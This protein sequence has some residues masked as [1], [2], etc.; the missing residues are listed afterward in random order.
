MYFKPPSDRQLR[1]AAEQR[2]VFPEIQ[3]DSPWGATGF[4]LKRPANVIG[5]SVTAYGVGSGS[6]GTRADLLICDDVVDVRA[7]TAQFGR[8]R[9]GGRVFREQPDEPAEWQNWLS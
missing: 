4:T 1:L 7:F 5:A 2:T 9:P 6:T 8:A 3:A